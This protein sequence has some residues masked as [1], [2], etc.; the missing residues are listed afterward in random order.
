MSCHAGSVNRKNLSGLPKIGS[1]TPPVARGAYH[2]ERQRRPLR[3]HTGAGRTGNGERNT[4]RA[5]AHNRLNRQPHR[6]S[7][8]E[9]RVPA[10]QIAVMS[11][12]Q[13]QKRSVQNEKCSRCKSREDTPLQ[14]QRLPVHLRVSERPEPE[15]IDPIRECRAA[16][17]D[18][19]GN[20]GDNNKKETTAATGGFV[21]G[22]SMK[23]G[24][25]PPRF[26]QHS[27]C[28]SYRKAYSTVP[29]KGLLCCAGALV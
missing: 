2:R 8:N 12:F 21:F 25:A 14:A 3:H 20:D 28:Q 4:E 26:C 16:A 1:T 23:S 29:E 7:I 17:K 19:A 27:R 22:Q 11:S 9:N 18:D 13:S 5:K 15:Q 6:P 10:G 24:N